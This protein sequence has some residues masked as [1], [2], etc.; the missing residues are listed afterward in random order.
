LGDRMGYTT[1]NLELGVYPEQEPGSR[2]AF[3]FFSPVSTF[4]DA[5]LKDK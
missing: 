4:W 1:V 5:F 2:Q 3:V